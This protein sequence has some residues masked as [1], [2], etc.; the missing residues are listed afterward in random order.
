[1]AS[2]TIIVVGGGQ[3]GG[4]AAKTLRA[5]GY[6]GRVVLVGDERHPPYERPPLSKSVLAGEAAPETTHLFKPEAWDALAL[7]VRAGERAGAIDRDAKELV[8]AGGE[9]IAYDA[10][11]LCTGGRARTLP[12]AAGD[13]PGVFTLRT[14]EDSLAIRRAL[15]GRAKR[16]AVIGGGWIGLEVA[17]TARLAGA[18]VTVIEALPRLCA[19]SV[20]AEVSDYLLSLHVRHGVNVLLDRAVVDLARDGDGALT[21]RLDD[22]HAL[23]ADVVVVGVGL[24]ANDELAR[25]AGLACDGGI[26]VDT[27][28][29]TSDPHVF[30][31]GDVAVTPN[32][33]AER[34]IRLES[35]QNAQ[36]Q[37][38]AA[39]KAALGQDVSYEPLPWFW[40]DQYDLKL[41]IYGLPS[42]SH[43][44]VMR[45]DP[46][47]GTFVAFYLD[48]E[49]VKAAVA[50]N[51]PRDLRVGRKL[52]EQKKSVSA[53]DLAD[54]SRPL[55]ALA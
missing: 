15:E 14:I 32:P 31:A 54:T 12:I 44:V 20:P 28:C 27:Q 55:A 6:T 19:R 52:I 5:E 16:V 33:W 48:G 49:L 17:A 39:A 18:D 29:R 4:W 42:A 51:S 47:C 3:A 38:I 53:A 23:T 30:A 24:V 45:G 1:M 10:L 43:Q 2:N 9:R 34:R 13:A 8:L 36:Y 35:W 37:G 11:I 41:Q 40:S 21:V 7:E 25:D 22:G 26:L 50:A 46:S